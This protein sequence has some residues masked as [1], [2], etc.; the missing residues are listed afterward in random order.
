MTKEQIKD[1]RDAA[2]TGRIPDEKNPLFLFQST[3]VELLKMILSGEINCFQL[4]EMEMANRGLDNDG[5]WIGFKNRV[6]NG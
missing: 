6:W 3:N 4:A 5:N 1:Y 2:K